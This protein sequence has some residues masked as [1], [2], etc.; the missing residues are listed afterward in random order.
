MVNPFSLTLTQ[1]WIVISIL[2]AIIGAQTSLTVF[3]IATGIRRKKLA[4]NRPLQWCDYCKQWHSGVTLINT[5]R[6]YKAVETS[7]LTK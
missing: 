3:I 5:H 2:L 1:A 4:A 6:R 7:M